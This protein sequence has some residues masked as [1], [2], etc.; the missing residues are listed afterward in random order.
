MISHSHQDTRL[1]LIGCG[2]HMKE[3]IFPSIR[4]TPRAE[5]TA[6]CSQSGSSALRF[7]E[8]MGLNARSVHG[9]KQLPLD[10]LDALVCSGPVNLHEEAVEFFI[11]AD[12]PLFV[13]KPIARNLSNLRDL[14]KLAGN[15]NPYIQIGYNLRFC[16][17]VQIFKE[18]IAGQRVQL[19]IHYGTNKP[20]QSLW[21]LSNLGQSFLL[22]IAVHP[23]NLGFHLLEK[24]K[25]ASI[26]DFRNKN[27]EIKLN[28]KVSTETGSGAD[29]SIS[30]TCKKFTLTL[31]ALFENGRRIE[32][33]NLSSLTET[34]AGEPTTEIWAHSPLKLNLPATGFGPQMAAFTEGIKKTRPTPKY[35]DLMDSLWM[36]ELFDEILTTRNQ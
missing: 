15:R 27:S 18:L 29:I 4:M 13:E 34:H 33:T 32:L 26:Q 7:I 3:S 25:S 8:E 19:S 1:G 28:V 21:N 20:R 12:K 30:N 10:E 35:Q 14:I 36:Y 31:G 6:V 5:I 24:F 17:G 22:A 11:K 9:L 23:L 2:S 16:T